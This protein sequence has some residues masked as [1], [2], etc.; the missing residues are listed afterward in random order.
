MLVHFFL[1]LVL[2][3]QSNPFAIPQIDLNDDAARQVVVD[4]E[5]GQYL[6]H[7]TTALL[8]DQKTILCVYPKGHGK[9][10]IQYKRSSDGGKRG[11]S[12]FPRPRVGRRP[13]KRQRST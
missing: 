5:D 8:D 12:D 9:G 11:L 7:P 3:Q 2:T 13:R 10:A 4:R 1:G 6:G